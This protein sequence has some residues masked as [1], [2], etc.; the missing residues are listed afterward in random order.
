MRQLA[1][2][3][4]DLSSATDCGI[5]MARS[6]LHTLVVLDDLEAIATNAEIDI[7]SLDTDSRSVSPKDAYKRVK[8]VTEVLLANGYLKFYKSIDSTLRGNIG[9]EVDAILD[10]AQFS[11]AV[12]APAFP[13]YGRTTR[14]GKHYWNGIPITQTE[15]ARDPQAP[16]QDDE[17]VRLVTSQSVRKAGLVDL[18]T[19][20][21]GADAVENRLLALRQRGVELYVFDAVEETDLDLIVETVTAGSHHVLW[22]GSTGLARCIPVTLRLPDCNQSPDQNSGNAKPGLLVIGSVSE[23]TR[24][25]AE[26]CVQN[27]LVHPVPVNPYAVFASEK[28][29]KNQINR[30]TEQLRTSLL[31]GEN[32]LLYLDSKRQDIPLVQDLGNKHGFDSIGVGLRLVKTL[33]DIVLQIVREDLISGV[34]LSGGDTAKAVCELLGAKGIE[35]LAEVEPG[36]PLCRLRGPH[37]LWVITKAGAFG[38]PEVLIDSLQQLK[39]MA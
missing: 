20:H 28:D 2:I 19:L 5:Q 6:G 13:H 12:L 34:V 4:D 27:K 33:A 31:N 24:K 22:V 7:L 39:R 18:E 26:V 38:T 25:Q 3:A 15:F 21:A 1:I 8:Q 29:D 37:P 14:D 23:I 32:G 16:V 17:L 35:I 30:C 11:G 9:A 36:I 10:S